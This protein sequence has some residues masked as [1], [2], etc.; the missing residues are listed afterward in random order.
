M[1][2]HHELMF[3]RRFVGACFLHGHAVKCG[4]MTIFCGIQDIQM[5]LITLLQQG[6]LL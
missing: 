3:C 1:V 5:F 6:L 4:T 2:Y